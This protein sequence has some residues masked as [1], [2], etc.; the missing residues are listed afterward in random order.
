MM[1]KIA[2]T[3]ILLTLAAPLSAQRLNLDFPGLAERADEIVDVTLDS[4]LLRVAAKFFTAGDRDERAIG[5][6]VSKLEGIYVRS[7]TFKEPNAYDRTIVDRV[8][9]QLGSNWKKIVTVRSKERENVEVYTDMR[10]EDIRGLVVISA[11]PRELTLV[12]IVGPID[13]ERLSQLK[14]LGVPQIEVQRER[15]QR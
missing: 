6:M 5:D 13:L 2:F 8:R 1:K 11:E 10:G 9:T 14:G 3:L 7:Y 4:T 15:K 12:N